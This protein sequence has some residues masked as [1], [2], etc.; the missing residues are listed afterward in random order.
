MNAYRERI[1]GLL[2]AD[3]PLEVLERTPRRLRELL[4]A[5]GRPGLDR[6]FGPEK[7]TARQVFAHLAD[8]EQAAGFRIR[9]IVTGGAGHVIQ[10]FDQD[11]WARTYS[12]LDARAAVRAHEALRAWNLSYYRTLEPSDLARVGLHPERGEESVETTIRM[13]AGHD[14]NHLAQLERIAAEAGAP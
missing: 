11:A 2:G 9:Q 7:W 10:P 8:V 3:E 13:L 4:E 1:L 6:P 12:R 14:R 5:L